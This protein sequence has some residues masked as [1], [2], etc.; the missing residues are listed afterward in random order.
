MSVYILWQ[1]DVTYF[2]CSSWLEY[3]INLEEKD[4]SIIRPAP[5]RVLVG[6]GAKADDAP[7]PLWT[8]P[9]LRL[10]M[11]EIEDWL[12][13]GCCA[14]YFRENGEQQARDL[15]GAGVWHQLTWIHICLFP[16][17]VIALGREGD[18]HIVV[19]TSGQKGLLCFA[20]VTV[21][22]LDFLKPQ[23]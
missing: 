11:E 7:Y 8:A 19:F 9:P 10:A 17:P 16:W 21:R 18:R 15:V 22:E 2:S 14:V 4:A 3:I 20:S 5:F 1:N 23:T 12:C 6:K 13:F